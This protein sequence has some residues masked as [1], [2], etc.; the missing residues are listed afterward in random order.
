[1][2]PQ[3]QLSL[4][5]Q[6]DAELSSHPALASFHPVVRRW[7]TEK[8][9]SPSEP[10]VLGWPE[11]RAGRDVLIA[12]PTGSGKTLTAFL[13]ALD[14]LFRQSLEGT[15]TDRTRV[16]YVSPLKALT[17][18][19]EKNLLKPLEEI[20]A[21]ASA[22]GFRPQPVRVQARTGDTPA[23]ER[24]AM[25][26]RP[27]HV[28]VT[29]PESLYLYLTSPKAR[30]TLRDVETVIVDEIHALARDKRGS[31]LALSLERLRHLVG[32]RSQRVGLSATQ[33][34]IEE[35]A[36]FLVGDHGDCAR[37][38][39]G[40]IRPWDVSVETPD[41]ELSAVA[42]HEAW[43]QIY[44]RLVALTEAH[45]T[46]LV[47][48]NTRRLAER[49]AHD[50]GGRLGPEWVHAHHGSMSRALRLKAED[51]LKRGELKVMVATASL[52]L[53]IDIGSV[54]LVVQLGTP[55]SIAVAL[56]RVGRA[57]HYYGGTSKGI[58]IAM[59]REE[60]V[61]C[62]AL[63]RSIR[64]GHLDA[65]VM[66]RKPLD[67]LAQQI[68]A[69][70]AA[71]EWDEDALYALC[72]RA[73]PYRD[74]TRAEFDQVLHLLSEG[75]ATSRGRS[76][77]HLH[78][79]RVNGRLRARKGARLQALTNGGAIPDTFTYPVVLEPEEKVVGTL[80]EDFAIDSSAGDVFLLGS[81]SWRI[82]RV[83][84]DAVR[85]EDA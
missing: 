24:S 43:G 57:G 48:A 35:I 41:E 23:S 3:P 29:T 71:D 79:D 10:Q 73:H 59:T 75:V 14:G 76:R 21:A 18:D 62:T 28:L 64:E 68:V 37:V 46:T 13:A 33:K 20:S 22:L 77:V 38:E 26:K 66:P 5:F 34:P 61:E 69:A 31:H 6:A 70:C 50:L 72:T 44:D 25:V 2:P 19:V 12:A 30:E 74:L 63:L 82:R 81:T 83:T 42:S 8:V 15:L 4:E 11:I 16:L 49:V 47:F 85:V 55:R 56:Q 84:Q 40:H 54:D 32:G 52:E 58:L 1:M 80:D 53:G 45:R 51:K 9:G 67:I 7:F 39:V 27:P 65:I 60:L 78:R 36:R 17:H